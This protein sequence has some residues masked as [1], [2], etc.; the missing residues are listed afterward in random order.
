MASGLDFENQF[1]NKY[2]I[3]DELGKGGFG[4]VYKV[5]SKATKIEYAIK[6]VAVNEKDDHELKQIERE[7]SLQKNQLNHPNIVKYFDCWKEKLIN[8]PE[9]IKYDMNSKF[10]YERWNGKM[11]RSFENKNCMCMRMP[12]YNGKY[13]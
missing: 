3:I 4:I 2:T 10:D 12:I 9:D 1:A 6:I 13:R 5:K 11:K 8:L 7:V